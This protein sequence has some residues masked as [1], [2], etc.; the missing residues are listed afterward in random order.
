MCIMPYNM[1]YGKCTT[2]VMLVSV[3]GR[4]CSPTGSPRSVS[5]RFNVSVVWDGGG[6]LVLLV[7][8]EPLGPVLP[9]TW[10]YVGVADSWSG[11]ASVG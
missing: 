2:L 8:F 1:L 7:P 6:M 10:D 3:I 4:D 5:T 11:R 9:S